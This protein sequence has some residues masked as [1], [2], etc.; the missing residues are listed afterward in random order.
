MLSV[1]G[2]SQSPRFLTTPT[3]S[4]KIGVEHKS[5]DLPFLFIQLLHLD[6]SWTIFSKNP[7]CGPIPSPFTAFLPS[8]QR[9]LRPCT[10]HHGSPRPLSMVLDF[11]TAH[12]FDC[13][14][15]P[16]GSLVLQSR[17]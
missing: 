5:M 9:T 15:L 16:C 17:Y 6:R 11:F 14:D 1:K 4:Q 12:V 3:T 2:H 8:C 7:T 10:L 13:G